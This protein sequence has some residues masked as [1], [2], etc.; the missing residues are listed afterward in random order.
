M[1]RLGI[2]LISVAVLLVAA[3]TA[4]AADV[5]LTPEQER[6]ALAIERLLRC[7]VCTGQSVAESHA[8][9]A[10]EIK[11]NIRKMIKEGKTRQE[12]I[13]YYIRRY[14]EWIVMKPPARGAGLIAWAW[15]V[16]VLVAGGLIINAF[17]RRS[18]RAAAEA[19][20]DAQGSVGPGEGVDPAVYERLK[21]YI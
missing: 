3:G 11:S 15:P 7:P 20:G 17:L 12:I 4:L 21:D 9:P 18:T 19:G 2:G 14:G 10:E 16:A 1:R 5:A 8:E 13:D 6:E